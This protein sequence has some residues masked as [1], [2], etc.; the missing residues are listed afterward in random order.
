MAAS[1]QEEEVFMI[2]RD[3]RLIE[4][5]RAGFLDGFNGGANRERLIDRP[6]RKF[7]HHG[8][9]FGKDFAESLKGQEHGEDIQP[10]PSTQGQDVTV[11]L[12]EAFT[13]F[14]VAVVRG[15]QQAMKPE[16]VLHV[17]EPTDEGLSSVNNS[18]A[19][20]GAWLALA[21]KHVAS[22]GTDCGIPDPL[23]TGAWLAGLK[24][25]EEGQ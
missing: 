17:L 20:L 6:F 9:R 1:E 3:K 22:N 4:T 19:I 25:P 8:H 7:Y 11:H 12:R 2:A 14:S 15:F 16:E 13:L 18:G 24:D 10:V 21:S 5:F 23:Q